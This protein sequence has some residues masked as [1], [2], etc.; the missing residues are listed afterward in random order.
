MSETVRLSLEFPRSLVEELWADETEASME[1]KEVF[2]LEFYRRRRIS[3]RRAA[4]IL[5]LSY[6]EF[7]DLA[8]R[9]KISP[10]EYEEGWAERELKGLQDL[11]SQ[12]I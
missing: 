9:H 12:A 1:M 2:V 3:L 5:S 7:T 8:S 11:H 4:E 10:F 6:G